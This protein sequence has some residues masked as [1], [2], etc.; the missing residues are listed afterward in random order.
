[1]KVG[2][3]A[4]NDGASEQR[5]SD[6]NRGLVELIACALGLLLASIQY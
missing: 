3:E 1:L 4:T 5:D 6:Q 2:N